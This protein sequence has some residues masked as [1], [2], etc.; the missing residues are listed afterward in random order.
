MHLQVLGCLA[1]RCILLGKR[2]CRDFDRD[3]FRRAR[4]FFH[5]RKPRWMPGIVRLEDY[6]E[7]R[8]W[9]STGVA[10]NVEHFPKTL[11]RD[12]ASI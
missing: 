5:A 12:S 4:Q 7:A 2:T 3:D 11:S 1:P 10:T 9:L 8:G 6:L